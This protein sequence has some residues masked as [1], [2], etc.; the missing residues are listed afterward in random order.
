MKVSDFVRQRSAPFKQLRGGVE[1][2][3]ELPKSAS[4]KILRRQ[5]KQQLLAHY[6]DEIVD[7]VVEKVLGYA[8]GRKIE[9]VDRPAIRE[10]IR[11]IEAQDYRMNSVIEEVV[12]SY[13]FLHK[14]S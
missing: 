8:L 13:P 7:Y 14:E 5:L 1:F 9:P 6:H 10:I 12:M 2:L 4:G 3:A 11:T